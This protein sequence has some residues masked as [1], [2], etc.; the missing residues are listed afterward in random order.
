MGL[1]P[2]DDDNTD[3][4]DAE[5][6]IILEDLTVPIGEPISYSPDDDMYYEIQVAPDGSCFLHCEQVRM[7]P[8]EWIN[9]K[10]TQAGF[11]TDPGRMQIEC[12]FAAD[13]RVGSSMRLPKMVLRDQS[14]IFYTMNMK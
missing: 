11:A 14:T 13:K 3:N 2:A 12:A 5:V 9:T 10:R 7:Y 8:I 6:V 4:G 1:S